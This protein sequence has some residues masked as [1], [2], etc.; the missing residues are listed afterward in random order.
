[1]RG[2]DRSDFGRPRRKEG[3]QG[4]FK[5]VSI[6]YVFSKELPFDP[7]SK[8]FLSAFSGGQNEIGNQLTD[9]SAVFDAEKQIIEKGALK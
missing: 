1:M 4:L 9:D 6:N 8:Q 3:G 2:S 7:Y 5:G